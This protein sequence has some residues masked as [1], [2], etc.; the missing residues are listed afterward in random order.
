MSRGLLIAAPASGSGK[1]VITL[2]LLR[3]LRRTGLSVASIKAGPDYIDPA[4]HAVASGRPCLNLDS[5]AMRRATLAELAAQ[6]GVGAELVLGEGVMG[7][8]DGAPGGAG[9]TAEL[10]ALTGWPVVLVVDAS[11][12]AASAAALLHGFVSYR[13]EVPIAAVIFNRV[14]GEGHARLLHEACDPL[15]LPVLGCVPRRD[16]LVLPDR[17]LG[18]VQA[19]EHKDLE[20]FLE[21]AATLVG[22]HLDTEALARLARPARLPPAAP[23]GPAVPPLGQRIAVARDPAFAFAYPFVLEGWRRAGA[24]VV[25]FS[26]L[27]DEAPDPAADAVYLPGG[28]PELHAGGLAA[29]G[30]F[31]DGLRGAAARG[32]SVYGECGGYMV[33]GRG[34]VDGAGARHPMAG[35]LPLETSFAEPRLSLGY[36]EAVV[37]ADG[38]LG[39]AG[40][41][42]RG[43][44]F[45]FARVLGTE[46]GS[47]LFRARDA[48]GQ[49]VGTAGLCAGTVLGSFLHL[50]DQA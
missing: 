29:N 37:V 31:L 48:R 50:V 19:S 38:P 45:H 21:G 10:A 4:F 3:H 46:D 1:T 43:H 44:E 32:A 11:G 24:E 40:A 18:L 34:L 42:F 8:F 12:M 49:P 20:A 15:G 23:A 5:W 9:S 22:G 25:C 28:Y 30:R 17:H 33:L 27:A 35:L 39:P 26:P 6:A 36:R 47:P 7:L 16:A 2:A 14:G 41:R 13:P